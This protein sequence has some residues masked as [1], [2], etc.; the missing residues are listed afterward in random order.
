MSVQ[1]DSPSLTR[2]FDFRAYLNSAPRAGF[3]WMPLLDVAII[4]GFLLLQGYPFFRAPGATVDLP[5]SVSQGPLDVRPSAVLSAGRNGL[6]FFD[7][8]KLAPA[9]LATTLQAYQDTHD[10]SGG[11]LLIKADEGLELTEIMSLMD[12]ARQAGFTQVHLAA[13]WDNRAATRLR[14][15]AEPAPVSR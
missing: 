5:A 3:E 6:L 13:D 8:R 12:A 15:A 1:P 10:Q 4:I 7:G 14:T 2:S 11:T 9:Q